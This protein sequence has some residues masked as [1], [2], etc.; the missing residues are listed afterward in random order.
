MKCILDNI[1]VAT[2]HFLGVAVALWICKT[3]YF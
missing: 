3:M 2:L 1:T